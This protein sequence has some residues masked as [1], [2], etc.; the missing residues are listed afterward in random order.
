MKKKNFFSRIDEE[1][2][3]IKN[4]FHENRKSL[5]PLFISSIYDKTSLWTTKTP[6]HLIV[7]RITDLAEK[8]LEL[9]EQQIFKKNTFYCQPLFTP[10]LSAYHCVIK[11]KRSLCAR[12]FE[13]VNSDEVPTIFLLPFKENPGNKN[14]QNKVPIVDFDPVANYLKEL[15]VKHYIILYNWY[16]KLLFFY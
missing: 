8:T 12:R 13:A 9:M 2:L 10:S 1:I 6:S 16:F 5:P 4:K 14:K 7:N 3:E 11:L 15:R